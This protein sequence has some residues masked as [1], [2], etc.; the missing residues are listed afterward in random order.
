[1][2][3]S[4][5]KISDTVVFGIPRSAS[6]SRTVSR[7]SL[8]IVART[9]SAFSGALL[10]ASLLE[11][12]SL[13]TDSLTI[14]EAFVPHFYLCCTY[15]I[16]PE[17][18]LNHLNSF[19]GRMFKINAKFDANSLLYYSV[20]WIRQPHST[21]AHSMA[22]NTPTDEYNEV[23]IVHT[24]TFQSTLLGCQVTSMCHTPFSLY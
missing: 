15:C 6:S 1:M 21:H 14:F 24:C 19:H 22:S 11:C 20:F 3:R 23:L 12:G 10:V 8:L 18:L 4:C 13:S 5:I 17:N 7:R 9:R 16:V 2:P